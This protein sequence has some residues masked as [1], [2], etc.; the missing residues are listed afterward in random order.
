MLKR[1]LL[2]GV[3]AVALPVA[4]QV[5]DVTWTAESETMGG[6]NVSDGTGT[7]YAMPMSEVNFY[8]DRSMKTLDALSKEQDKCK[9]SDPDKCYRVDVFEDRACDGGAKVRQPVGQGS[10]SILGL[11]YAGSI[12]VGDV[13]LQQAKLAL[14]HNKQLLAKGNKTGWDHSKAKKVKRDDLGKK[15]KE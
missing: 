6:H 3:V 7:V 2:F 11:T 15:V 5:C 12:R 1:Y 14:D 9:E 10:A 13:A 4:A 8:H